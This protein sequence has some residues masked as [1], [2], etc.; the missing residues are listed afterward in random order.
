MTYLS[1]KKIYALLICLLWYAVDYEWYKRGKESTLKTIFFTLC[2]TSHAFC[3]IPT[4]FCCGEL[5][6]KSSPK[7]STATTQ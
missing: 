3:L 6:F 2:L 5:H 7:I 1:L 4:V